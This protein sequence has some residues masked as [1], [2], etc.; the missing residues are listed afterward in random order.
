MAKPQKVEIVENRA[1]GIQI[2]GGGRWV[3]PQDPR[4][5]LLDCIKCGKSI[6]AHYKSFEEQ[7]RVSDAEVTKLF[8]SYGWTIGPT[9]CNEHANPDNKEEEDA[10]N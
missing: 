3:G 6:I 2:G 10:T 5:I 7:R 1:I 9:L 8:S 4:T